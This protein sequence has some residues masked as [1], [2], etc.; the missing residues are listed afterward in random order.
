MIIKDEEIN[1]VIWFTSS[2]LNSSL[3]SDQN[4]NPR[5]IKPGDDRVVG[6][7]FTK[8]H[9]FITS[10]IVDAIYMSKATTSDGISIG[11]KLII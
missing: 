8:V 2:Q 1:Q 7:W 3:S 10:S 4:L 5:H 9:N 11:I 6:F